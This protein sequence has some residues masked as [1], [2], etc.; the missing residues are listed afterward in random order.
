VAAALQ[1]DTDKLVP[2]TEKLEFQQEQLAQMQAAMAQQQQLAAPQGM[3]P[4]GNPAGGQDANLM[5]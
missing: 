5:Q 4:A 2:T 3:D 1:M